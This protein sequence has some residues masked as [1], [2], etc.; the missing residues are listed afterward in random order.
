MFMQIFP[1]LRIAL[2]V[3]WGLITNFC[4]GFQ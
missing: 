3:I 4:G 2:D 1:G